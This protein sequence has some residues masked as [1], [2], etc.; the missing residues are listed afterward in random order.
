[1]GAA[2]E[3]LHKV[4]KT[5]HLSAE[6][7]AAAM[8][9][10]LTGEAGPVLVSGLLVALCMKGETVDEIAG[11]ARAMR[12]RAAVIPLRAVEAASLVDTCGTGGDSSH[13]FNISTVSAFVVAGAGV[14]VAKHGNRSISSRCGSA[15][16]LEA[17]GASVQLTPEQVAA[18][19]ESVGIGFLF[20]PLIH[21]A[22]RHAQP[23][24][25]ELKMRT[26]FNMLGPLTNPAGAGAQVMGVFDIKLVAM[27]AEVLAGLGLR[28]GF[29]VHGSDG[30][31]EITTTGATLVAEIADGKVVERRLT[32]DD[33]GL[34]TAQPDDLV[35][36]DREANAAI[37]REILAGRPGPRRDIVVANAAAA[38]VAAGRAEDFRDG[39][40]LSAESIDSGKALGALEEFVRFTNQ[41][42]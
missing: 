22:M 38:L 34:P 15:D 1:M 20:A 13:S 39:A 32:P 29:V 42:S 21:P 6:E 24:R 27:I 10:I 5:E 30:L 11:F 7:A 17:L 14:P 9:E 8:D 33:F 28:R 2:L 36:G 19:I 26:V 37:A 3:A 16:V 18:S 31:D 23:V 40:V 4:V 41:F 12:A 25:A 35:G